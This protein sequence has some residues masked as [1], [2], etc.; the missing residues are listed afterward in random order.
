MPHHAS[1]PTRQPP[2]DGNP[3]LQSYKARARQAPSEHGLAIVRR[4]TPLGALIPALAPLDVVDLDQLSAWR[5]RHRS[6]FFSERPASAAS[7]A[8][9][10][11]AIAQRDDRVLFLITVGGGRIVGHIGLNHVDESR[12]CGE[13]DAWLGVG[14]GRTPGLM[15]LAFASLVQW[16]FGHLRLTT[17]RAQVFS[18]N[19]KVIRAHQLLGFQVDGAVAFRRREDGSGV[20]W[21]PG[22]AADAR[23]VSQLRLDRSAFAATSGEWK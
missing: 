23:M 22:E 21:E 8:S 17:L 9:W 18:D 7:T 12:Q 6:A 19:A 3:N 11:A 10:L 1:S 4:G 20:W 15:L 16:A 2:Q 13:T 14:D 5:N